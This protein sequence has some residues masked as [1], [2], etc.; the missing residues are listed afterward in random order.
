MAVRWGAL[1]LPEGGGFGAALMQVRR[2]RGQRRGEILIK[3]QLRVIS[4]QV[5]CP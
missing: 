1:R 4:C 3:C 2:C 5:R